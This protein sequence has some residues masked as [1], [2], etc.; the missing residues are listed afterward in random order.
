[1]SS[2]SDINPAGN[3]NNDAPRTP[4]DIYFGNPQPDDQYPISDFWSPVDREIHISCEA[5]PE[6][7]YR[8]YLHKLET[9][10]MISCYVPRRSLSNS[11]LPLDGEEVDKTAD[12]GKG[13]QF[14]FASLPHAFLQSTEDYCGSP[15]TTSVP[16][17]DC[18]TYPWPSQGMFLTHLLFNGNARV[19]YSETQKKAIINWGKALGAKEVPVLSALKRVQTD[20]EEMVG[21]P[22]EKVVSSTGTVFYINEVAHA[23]AKDFANP[24]TR[25]AMAEYPEDGG[26]SL[27]EM[28]HGRKWLI[29]IP[30]DTL[31]ITARVGGKLYFVGE[32]LQC[33]DGSYFIPD[34][35]FTRPATSDVGSPDKPPPPSLFAFGNAVHIT[36]FHATYEELLHAG[37][38]SRGFSGE[39]FYDDR[40]EDLLT[41]DT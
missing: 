7:Y 31:T 8:A 13:L 9:E 27:S 30:R 26:G 29:E 34:H 28:K 15:S 11:E 22:T 6:D 38:L 36:M 17:L 16:G 40:Q 41:L 2:S 4:N 1:M 23:I 21:S 39:F 37:R 14:D 10:E 19:P 33:R 24:I 5:D 35:F 12:D 32:L 20:V 18:P 25:L 3:S